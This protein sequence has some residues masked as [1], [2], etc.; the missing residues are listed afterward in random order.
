MWNVLKANS[1][2]TNDLVVVSSL[3]TLNKFQIFF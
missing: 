3:L 1:K 2:D